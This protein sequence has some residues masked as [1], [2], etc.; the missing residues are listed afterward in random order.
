[1]RYPAWRLAAAAS[2]NAPGSCY[3]GAAGG[4]RQDRRPGVVADPAVD[5]LDERRAAEL[6]ERA[7]Q[8]PCPLRLAEQGAGK[9]RDQAE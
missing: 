4:R 7:D 6:R 9:H 8:V 1:M 2:K 3:Q 5:L